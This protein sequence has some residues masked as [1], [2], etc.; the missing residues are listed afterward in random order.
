MLL[1]GAR[2]RGDRRPAV[3]GAAAAGGPYRHWRRLGSRRRRR[4]PGWS[5]SRSRGRARTRR[6][7]AS[8]RSPARCGALLEGEFGRVRVRGE[9]GRVSRPSSGHVYFD[10]KDDR[11]CLGALVWRSGVRGLAVQPQEGMEVVATGRLTTH[12]GQSKYQMVVEALA[13]AGVGA[14]M[15][16]LEARKKA[17][18]AEGLFAA[19]RKRPLPY[20]PEVIGVVTSPSGAVIRDILHRLSERFPRKVLLWPVTVQGRALRA[21]GGG[22]DPG[23]QRDRARRAG[24]A[25]GRDHRGARRRLDR[26]PLGVQRGD[27]GAGGGGEPDP[28]DLGGRAR[29]RH[30]ADRLRRRPAGADADRG[31]RDGGAGAARAAGGAGPARRAAGGGAGARVRAAGAAA[32]RPRARAAAAGG[33]DR[34]SGRSGSTG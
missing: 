24:A 14:L 5:F 10:L 18:E 15:A 17:L 1:I 23:V 31:R 8:R 9:V 11:A 13:P 3:A 22:G 2:P 33:A 30:H 25:A 16:M 29:D 34:A 26:G 19:E 27:R 32:A 21:G 12:A 20:L 4:E 7:S 6:S 28:A